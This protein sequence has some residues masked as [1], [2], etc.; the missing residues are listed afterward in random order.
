MKKQFLTTALLSTMVLNYVAPISTVFAQDTDSK[1]SAVES[2]ISNLNSQ[3][4]AAQAQV[5]A[6]QSSVDK[7]KAEQGRLT[8]ENEKLQA[9][10]EA[11]FAEIQVLSENIVARNEALSAQARSAQTEGTAVNY[12]NT[13]LDSSSIADAVSRVTAMT[14]I[15]S[16]NN[17]M[18]EQQEAD[19]AAI[20]KKQKANQEAINTIATNQKKLADDE[21]ALNTQQAE[22]EVAKLNLAAELSTAEGEKK[23]LLEQKAA[24]EAAAAKAAAEEAAYRAAQQAQAQALQASAAGARPTVLSGVNTVTNAGDTSGAS[25]ATL[26]DSTVPAAN[27]ATPTNTAKVTYSAANTYP[28]G[29]CTWGAKALAP[30]VGNYWGNAAQWPASAQAAGYSV[31][32]TPVVG[33][34]AVWPYDGG[35]YGHVAVVTAVQSATNIQVSESNY[36]G[37]QSISNYRGWFN[38]TAGTWGGGTVLY[39]YP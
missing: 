3:Q 13:V 25:A 16:A 9:E 6:I 37:S 19:K 17:Q 34:V 36:A 33:A 24:A 27:T 11:L 28:V 18:L 26:S 23:S 12:I 29:Q 14:E 30:W 20:E 4:A 21:Q 15:I 2:K 1:I 35:G 5:N 10:S 31:G 32:T 38:P 22:L 39:I 7:I 8:A